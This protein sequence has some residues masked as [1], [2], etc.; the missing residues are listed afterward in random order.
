MAAKTPLRCHTL[1]QAVHRLADRL[2]SGDTTMLY[3]ADA[4]STLAEAV[5]RLNDY[6]GLDNRCHRLQVAAT[7]RTRISTLRFAAKVAQG[8]DSREIDFG[9]YFS[10]LADRWETHDHA[11]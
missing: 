8:S 10:D 5:V 4:I 7:L 1:S 9:K 6:A 3:D 11:S 2:N